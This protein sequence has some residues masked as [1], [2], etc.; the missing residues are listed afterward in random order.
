MCQDDAGTEKSLERMRKRRVADETRLRVVPRDDKF[1][2]EFADSVNSYYA[3][4][5][6]RA[7][8][9][10][11]QEM[12]D[13]EARMEERQCNK[14][15]QQLGIEVSPSTDS[16]PTVENVPAPPKTPPPISPRR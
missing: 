12:L 3:K 13:F 2:K 8:A 7:D 14:L 6:G 15:A 1:H 9:A 16:L 11:Q 10:H 4:R 5:N